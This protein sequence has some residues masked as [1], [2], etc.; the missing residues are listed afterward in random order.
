MR[1]FTILALTACAVMTTGCENLGLTRF[2]QSYLSVRGEQATTIGSIFVWSNDVNAAVIYN[3][4]EIC[5]QRAMTVRETDIAANGRLS[6]AVEQLAAATATAAAEDASG[7]SVISLSTTITETAKL[8]TTTTER[9]AFL[10][11]GLF[12]LCQL[13]GNYSIDAEQTA[14]L[15]A[16]LITAAGALE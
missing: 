11:I 5:A 8:L 16:V 10:D 14:A 9:T 7:Q 13:S 6:A 2:K 12:Y 1:S 4:G 15:T 3:T